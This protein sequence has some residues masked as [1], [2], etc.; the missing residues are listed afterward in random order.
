MWRFRSRRFSA[1]YGRFIGFLDRFRK[2]ADLPPPMPPGA[3]PDPVPSLAPPLPPPPVFAKSEGHDHP[4][5]PWGSQVGV[6]GESFYQE[7]FLMVCGP[8]CEGGYFLDVVAELRPEP[9]N[10]YD[11]AAVGV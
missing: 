4:T 7:A 1:D 11:A 6:V 8:K 5:L 2:A 10:E 3:W 9:D